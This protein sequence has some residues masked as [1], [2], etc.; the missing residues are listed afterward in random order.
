M[1]TE[2]NDCDGYLCK[3]SQKTETITITI[4]SDSYYELREN[5]L[6]SLY[7][8]IFHVNKNENGIETKITESMACKTLQYYIPDIFI[9]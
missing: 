3:I 4:H 9:H 5:K 2:H 8:Y 1:G 6:K 7:M